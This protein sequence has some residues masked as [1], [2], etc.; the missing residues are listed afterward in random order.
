MSLFENVCVCVCV[1]V[2]YLKHNEESE[3]DVKLEHTADE[4]PH[5]HCYTEGCQGNAHSCEVQGP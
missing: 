4:A 2:P 3:N 1:C 5:V